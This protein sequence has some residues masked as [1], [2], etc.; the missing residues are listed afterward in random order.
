MKIYKSLT[1]SIGTVMKNPEML[2]FVP[3]QEMC[4]K[5][6]DNYPHTLRFVP[7]CY[8]TQVMCDKVVNTYSST[9]KFAPECYKTQNIW[10]KVFNKCFLAFFIFLIDIKIKQYV[11]DQYKTQR[12][13]EKA[14]DD[15][16]TALKFLPDWFVKSKMIKIFTALYAD[17]N[18]L[19]FSED[20]GNVA[21]I[22]NG[23]GILNIDLNNINLDDN[24][25]D[26][27]Y[28]DT[29]IHVKL[30]AWHIKFEKGKALKNN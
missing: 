3:D 26:E 7:E 20:S 12:M 15:C 8:K 6:V 10:D 16:L 14:F 29:I 19:H 13:C 24:N 28:P 2:K 17:E 9:I 30:L 1:I 5:A 11:S 25:Y 4:N 27:C 23:M 18:I 21:F 22:C